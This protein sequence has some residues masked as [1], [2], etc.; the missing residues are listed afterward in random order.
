MSKKVFI[1][2]YGCQMNVHDSEKM[3]GKLAEKG[4]VAT[5]N[6]E[7]ADLIVFNTCAIREKA[8]QKFYSQLG[9]TKFLKRKKSGLKIAVAGC[10]A[11]ESR[12]KIFRKAPFVDFLLG[13]QNIQMINET[14]SGENPRAALDEN[15]D[16]ATETVTAQRGDTIRAWVSIM[17]GCNN[18]CSYCIVPYTRGREVSR[19]SGKIV[20]EIEALRDKGY[21]EVTLLGQNVNS[22]RSDLDFTNL[23]RRVDSTGIERLRFVTSHPRDISRELIC[24]MPGLPSVC[25]HLHLPIQ[26]GSDGI[27]KL[28]NRGYTYGQ[29]IEKISL[30]R[31]T[32]P[33]VSITTDI[34]VGFPG[35]SEAD[36]HSTLTALKEIEFDGIF[37]FKYSSRKG[38]KACDMTDHLGEEV[39]TERL[40]A[41][42]KTQEE[43]TYRKNKA[44]EGTDQDI[45]VE[46]P[47][48]TDRHM[49]TGRTRTNKI[50]TF[51]DSGE[52]KGTFVRV[53]IE[54]A[55][56]HSL[57]GVNAATLDLEG[58]REK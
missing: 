50:V 6:P 36:Y 28:M 38:T 37:A 55:R 16:I 20:S 30:L 26:S 33:V 1:Y 14:I 9:R 51:P 49:L 41:L 13:Q 22:Y 53:R 43:I 23:L 15:P 44:L 39:K 12:E 18:F 56:L 54:R 24:S 8:E 10:V 58:S 19:P 27:L 40:N 35:E 7:N 46:G 11:Q 48:E 57:D 45:L 32:L 3:L 25:E 17:Y 31:R 29:Y 47:S 21:R 42:L 34:I 5:G 2:T 4:Y 52:G